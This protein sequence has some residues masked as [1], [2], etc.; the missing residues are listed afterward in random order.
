MSSPETTPPAA[1]EKG[2]DFFTA[3]ADR[4]EEPRQ[5]RR[6]WVIAGLV[7]VGLVA[8]GFAVTWKDPDKRFIITRHAAT[9]IEPGM[10]RKEIVQRIGKPTAYRKHD[11]GRDCAQYSNANLQFPRFS[12]YTLCYDQ[13]R[14][15]TVEERRFALFGVM[16]EDG[17]FDGPPGHDIEEAK[18]RIKIF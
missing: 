5:A 18:K 8:V 11:D 2:A 16:R 10:T 13:D 12:I 15:Q 17:S 7:A 9:H 1:P 3:F 4:P 6:R 14:L